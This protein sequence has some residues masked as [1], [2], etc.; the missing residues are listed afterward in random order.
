MRKLKFDS[1]EVIVENTKI[2]VLGCMSGNAKI[3]RLLR[4]V[5]ADFYFQIYPS[6]P[7]HLKF[8]T[9]VRTRSLLNGMH[10]GLV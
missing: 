7:S 3:M 6:F 1:W 2:L 8:Y 10:G 5:F 4:K 9:S